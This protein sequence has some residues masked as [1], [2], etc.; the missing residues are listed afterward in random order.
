MDVD[1]LEGLRSIWLYCLAAPIRAEIRADASPTS[2]SRL[3]ASQVM[4]ASPTA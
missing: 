4:A 2:S 3:S 1:L